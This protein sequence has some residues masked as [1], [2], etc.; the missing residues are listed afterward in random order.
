MEHTHNNPNTTKIE[1]RIFFVL[2]FFTKVAVNVDPMKNKVDKGPNITNNRILMSP[3][4][5]PVS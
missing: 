4:D 5:I 3:Y 1:V 2:A